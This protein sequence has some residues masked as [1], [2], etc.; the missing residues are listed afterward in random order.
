MTQGFTKQLAVAA[1]I[2]AS[3]VRLLRCELVEP[4]AGR[5]GFYFDATQ[6]QVENLT[7]TY[8]SG[9][10]ISGLAFYRALGD[11][12]LKVNRILNSGGAR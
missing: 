1:F 6:G 9:E 7:D 8:Y 5:V 11:L 2:L 3:G 10:P 12:R 4:L